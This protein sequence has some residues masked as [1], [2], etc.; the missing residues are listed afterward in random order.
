[1][2][3][4]AVVS[5]ARLTCQPHEI[6]SSPRAMRLRN[7]DPIFDPAIVAIQR[8]GVLDQEVVVQLLAAKDSGERRKRV[9]NAVTLTGPVVPIL[10]TFQR[11]D[12]LFARLQCWPRPS[13]ALSRPT[14]TAIGRRRNR[15]SGGFN[16]PESGF[17]TDKPSTKSRWTRMCFFHRTGATRCLPAFREAGSRRA[18][19]GRTG[20]RRESGVC[21]GAVAARSPDTKELQP[22]GYDPVFRVAGHTLVFGGR[23][24]TTHRRL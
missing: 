7:R 11:H 20:D 23:S 15:G 17:D 19:L 21:S 24:R 18:N 4:E 13:H 9:V 6:R 16:L 14:A 3:T 10:P 22:R 8:G 5:T 1:M 12:S 2:G